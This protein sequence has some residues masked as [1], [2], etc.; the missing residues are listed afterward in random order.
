MFC[1]FHTSDITFIIHLIH[2][3]KCRKNTCTLQITKQELLKRDY[4]LKQGKFYLKVGNTTK[5]S[6]NRI[7]QNT[8]KT[9][10]KYYYSILYCKSKEIKKSLK[11]SKDSKKIKSTTFGRKLNLAIYIITTN[12]NNKYL[13]KRR[14]KIKF[15]ATKNIFKNLRKSQ[16]GF[17]FKFI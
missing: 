17:H 2:F 8:S 11:G 16:R 9:K 13:P 7:H 14:E 1:N 15:K 6:K 4:L 10:N 12:A 3:N 5:I